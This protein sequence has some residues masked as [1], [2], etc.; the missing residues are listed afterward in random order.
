VRAILLLAVALVAACASR[1]ETTTAGTA[2]AGL[3]DFVG[4]WNATLRPQNNSGV[5]GTAKLQTAVA[6][7]AVT[8]TISG[9]MPNAHLPWHIHSGTCATGGPIV[10]S[11]SAY[12]PLHVAANGTATATTSIGV[13]LNEEQKY[14]VNV[15]KSDTEMNVIISC[16]DLD[17]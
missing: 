4:D 7:S 12:P 16:G 2:S 13:A 5:G 9:A 1:Q 10:G 6:A 8:V 15:H 11:A 17:N 3:G 14:H